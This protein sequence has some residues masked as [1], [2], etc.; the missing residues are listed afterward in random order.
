MEVLETLA[1]LGSEEGGLVRV[2]SPRRWTSAMMTVLP[3]RVML[4]VPLIL[5]RRD[6]LLPLS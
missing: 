4:G 2:K 1:A 3:P 6:T 5:A